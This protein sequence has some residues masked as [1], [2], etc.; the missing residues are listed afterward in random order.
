MR[1]PAPEQFPIP[2]YETNP[3]NIELTP[4]QEAAVDLTPQREYFTELSTSDRK[5]K[6][7]R[8]GSE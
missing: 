2:K 5:F 1:R 7:S 8:Q 4:I 6:A 3:T